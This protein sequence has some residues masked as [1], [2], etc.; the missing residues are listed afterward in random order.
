MSRYT[1]A[2]IIDDESTFG[3]TKDFR[4]FEAIS[5]TD[6]GNSIKEGL[7]RPEELDAWLT[8]IVDASSQDYLHY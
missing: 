5:S 7:L 3:L 2:H 8:E 6:G 1:Y 4:Y